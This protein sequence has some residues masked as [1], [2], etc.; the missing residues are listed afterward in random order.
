MTDLDLTP[1]DDGLARLV[2]LTSGPHLSPAFL[3]EGEELAQAWR[4]EIQ[5]AGL[6]RT[7]AYEESV[8]AR[9]G[10]VDAGTAQVLVGTDLGYPSVL[11]YGDRYIRPYGVAHLAYSRDEEAIIAALVADIEAQFGE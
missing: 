10:Q 9:Q 6:I 4:A 7:G 8:R 5:S 1:L 11:E 3:R 2:E